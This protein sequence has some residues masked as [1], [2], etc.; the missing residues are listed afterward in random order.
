[1]RLALALE[2]LRI[3]RS[4]V[5]SIGRSPATYLAQRL[6]EEVKSGGY[7]SATL[8]P[9]TPSGSVRTAS[10]LVER[11]LVIRRQARTVEEGA[12]K[13]PITAHFNSQDVDLTCADT[14]IN[15]TGQTTWST[16]I[17]GTDSIRVLK[18]GHKCP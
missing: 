1:M 13:V 9:G 15:L 4:R 2:E 16:P 11:F 12:A 14:Q 5:S 3:S 8:L 10:S 17:Q 18:D 6:L 7:E